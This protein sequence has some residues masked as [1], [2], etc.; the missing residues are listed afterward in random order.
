MSRRR[1]FLALAL[2]LASGFAVFNSLTAYCAETGQRVVRL[3]VVYTS[4]PSAA[5]PAVKAFWDRLHE[6][7]YVEGQNLVIEQRWAEGQLDKLP[8][9]MAEVLARNLDVLVTWTTPGARAAKNATS[10]VPIVAAAMGD[11]VGSGLVVSLARPGGNLTGLSSGWGRGIGGKWLEL[12]QETVPQLSTVAVTM[13]PD[14]PVHRD[15]V[16]ELEIIAPTR[17]VKLRI[18]EVRNA[19]MLEQ[20]FEHARRSAQ[21]VM[22]VAE[23]ITMNNRTQ[24]TML[25]AKHRLPAIYG[26][27]DFVD[28]GGLMAY[29]FDEVVMFRRAADYVDKIVKGANPAD[30]PIEQVSSYQLIVNLKTA[31]ALGLTFPES[32]L[33]RADEVIR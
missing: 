19:Q 22:V 7:G 12:L 30:L 27:R 10:T 25:A 6:L 21:A 15:L 4:S 16:K 32:I 29:G 20:V 11:P 8:A 17:G 13:N 9:L 28:S 31:K 26:L 5:Q 23:P 2:S 14:I 33:Q 3:A 1:T 24:V 18:I